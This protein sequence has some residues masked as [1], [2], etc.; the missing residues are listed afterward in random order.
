[1]DGSN[2]I[3]Q[4]GGEI[5]GEHEAWRQEQRQKLVDMGGDPSALDTLAAACDALEEEEG[6]SEAAEVQDP[7]QKWR[8]MKLPALLKEARRCRAD[9]DAMDAAMED[10]APRESL[11]AILAST[12]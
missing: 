2:F 3:G 12:C 11:M 10:D 5:N 8:Q 7:T 4:L 6:T 1:M 9:E